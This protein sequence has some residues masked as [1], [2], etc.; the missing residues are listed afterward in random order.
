MSE[1]VASST[2]VLVA[3]GRAVADGRYAVARFSDPIARELL[4]PGEREVVDRVRREQVPTEAAGRF[5]Y[6]M[7]RRTG[8]S[9]APRTIAI[10]EAVR[11]HAA[12]QLVILGAGL[13]G[14]AW[15]MPELA[16]VH[17]FEVDH[18]A[19]QRDKLRRVERLAVQAGA[20]SYVA[21][22]LASEPLRPALEAA[23]YDPQQP[24]TWV[25][26]GVV[27]YLTADEVRATVAQVAELTASGSRLVVN[28]Q[29]RSLST[30][31]M[32]AV[33]RWV[34]R[35]ARQPDPMAGEPWRSKWSPEAMRDMLGD[36]GF[37]VS[38]DDD[39]LS[40]AAGLELPGDNDSSLRNGRVAVAGRT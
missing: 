34:L 16:Q 1:R 2:A 13:D 19:S 24:S 23:G 20:I 12:R 40:L 37:T 32:R 9:M 11:S 29:A 31:V 35:V 6:E 27:P 7:V 33:M 15:R 17:V 3:Q 30:S 21:V 28:Y 4:D 38:S 14:R 8:I 10:D 18:P 25:W 26:E 39:L 5:A 22:D 36:N